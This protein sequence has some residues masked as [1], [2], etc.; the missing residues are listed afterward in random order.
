MRLK[1]ILT[2]C[3]IQCSQIVFADKVPYFGSSEIVVESE[4]YKIV[5][6]HDWSLKDAEW[7]YYLP[8]KYHK[9][10]VENF[11]TIHCIN[12]RNGRTVF[13]RKCPPLTF[14][15]ISD[16]E[17]FIVGLSNINIHNPSQLV[18][19][20]NNGRLLKKRHIALREMK[21]SIKEYKTL[22]RSEKRE[23]FR[24]KHYKYKIGD[25]I[26]VDF[27]FINFVKRKWIS[28]S[29]FHYISNNH[30]SPNFSSSM[31]NWIYWY[32]SSNPDIK[33]Q[34]KR[35]KLI[36]ISLLDPEAE[37]FIVKIKE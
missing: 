3:I 27:P 34:M 16:D 28:I 32:N 31:G 2:L 36:A 12:K 21:L 22:R 25:S 14:I 20:N 30:L 11:G 29:E 4:N 18:I 35:R 37:R 23:L 1:I 6:T 33:Y 17:R 10:R 9:Y 19:Y 24:N 8:F 7:I 26:Y 15:D 5:H 13:K